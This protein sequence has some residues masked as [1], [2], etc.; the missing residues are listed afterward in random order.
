MNSELEEESYRVAMAEA[1]D[2][3]KMEL[4]GNSFSFLFFHLNDKFPFLFFTF[5]YFQL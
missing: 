3:R 4:E 5:A 2:K 1:Y